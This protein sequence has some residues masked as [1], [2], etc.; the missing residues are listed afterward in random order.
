MRLWGVPAAEPFVRRRRRGTGRGRPA[1]DAGSTPDDVESHGA[2]G[3]AYGGSDGP[4]S[5]G[6]HGDGR[7]WMPCWWTPCPRPPGTTRSAPPET[8]GSQAAVGRFSRRRP[9]LREPRASVRGRG[10]GRWPASGACWRWTLGSPGSEAAG[11]GGGTRD[12]TLLFFILFFQPAVGAGY[13]PRAVA[14]F[15]GL[16]FTLARVWSSRR[17]EARA[18]APHEGPRPAYRRRRVTPLSPPRARARHRGRR[19]QES[20]LG[21]TSPAS[22]R[23]LLRRGRLLLRA[24]G[25]LRVRLFAGFAVGVGFG[26]VAHFL[27][28]VLAPAPRRARQDRKVKGTKLPTSSYLPCSLLLSRNRCTSGLERMRLPQGE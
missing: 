26:R 19:L 22:G 12:E 5:S 16:V 4:R 2:Y 14:A 8:S 24:L 28:G 1:F 3:D 20:R 27:L 25:G 9:S 18:G 17:G 13:A 10:A 15:G 21:S 6:G 11:I 7:S 23:R